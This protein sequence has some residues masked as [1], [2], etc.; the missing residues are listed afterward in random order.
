MLDS[1][2]LRHAP[3]NESG[4]ILLFGMLA[5]R[6]GFIV[7]A[8]RVNFPDCEAIRKIGPDKWERMRIEFEYESRNF[9]THKHDAAGC[10]LIVCW[11][12][13]WPECPV[14]VLALKEKCE[15]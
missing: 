15:V 7:D 9:K 10:D 5:E 6:L 13:N 1:G 4:V 12:H 11:T 8:V 14:E 3:V 2:A